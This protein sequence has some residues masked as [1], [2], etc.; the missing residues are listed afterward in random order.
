MVWVSANW[1]NSRG[2][3]GPASAAMG[4]NLPASRALPVVDRLR[5]AA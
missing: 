4:I 2:Q 5:V 3:T 1:Q